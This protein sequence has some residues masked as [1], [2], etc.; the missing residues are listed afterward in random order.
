MTHDP[1]PD[2]T[3]IEAART[4]RDRLR[5]TDD[6]AA[7]CADG[8][9]VT[10][11]D[12]RTFSGATFRASTPGLSVCATRVALSRARAESGAA[13]AALTLVWV[14]SHTRTCGLCRQ[15][16]VELAPGADVH[17]LDGD[18]LTPAGGLVALPEPFTSFRPGRTS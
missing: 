11:A 5:G 1:D 16:I 15:M 18:S 4:L 7:T 6:P 13:I 3:P 17:R 10:T 9:V 14:G 8:A 12:G 2:D